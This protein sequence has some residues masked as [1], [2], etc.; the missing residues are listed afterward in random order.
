[1]IRLNMYI[2][3]KTLWQMGKSKSEI[4]RLTG[5]DRKTVRKIIKQIKSGAEHPIKEAHP[6]R[7]D[8]YKESILEWMESDL[9]GVRIH[10]NLSSLGVNVSYSTVR[11]IIHEIKKGNN[12][13]IRFHTGPGEE[14]QVDFGYVGMTIDDNGKK[15]KTWV[16]NMRLSYS[17]LDYYEKVYDQKVETF[18]KC[19]INAFEYFEGVP[20]YVKIDNLKA[21]IL[22]ANFHEP[23]YQGLFKTFAEYYGF[24]PLPCRV[25]EPQEK[26]K[27]ESGIK[28][29]KDNFFRGRSFK[30]EKDL[31]ERLRYWLEH[32]C[33]SRVHG[34][35]R[36]VPTELFN[37][38][39]KDKLLKLPDSDFIIPQVG[40]RKVYHDCH[41]YIEYNYYSVPFEYVG[42]TVEVEV[43][44]NFVKVF[45]EY[46]QIAMHKRL[47]DKGEFSTVETHYP[48]YKNYL[49][50]EYQESYQMKMRGIG[51]N[52]EQIFLSILERNRYLW[53]R[54]VSGILSLRKIYPD[55][56]I[57][58]ACRRALMY[59]VY[60]YKRIK[61]ICENGS[62]N[63][64]ME[65]N[66]EGV[67]I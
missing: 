30:S 27:V 57:D 33:N 35:T 49:S 32:T 43:K 58:K 2:T 24:K 10:Q 48:K 64:P 65:N 40:T 29:V 22:N 36:K 62:Y 12:I 26:G 1:M 9:S 55:E 14:A 61:S 13:S 20:V 50:T 47:M 23:E 67:R 4:S 59:N 60:N 5:H 38:Q 63:L 52:A 56:I 41:V 15:R 31:V 3:I 7:L 18:I 51:S 19:H 46:K 53:N 54:P 37:S 44:D 45:Y 16:F 25:R 21:A 39:E 34:T 6:C 8:P 17:R 42:K 28:Y 66:E 11:D